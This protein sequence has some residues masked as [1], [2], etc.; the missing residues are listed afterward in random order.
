MKSL[1]CKKLVLHTDGTLSGTR[2]LLDDQLVDGV[3]MISLEV[4]PEGYDASV[5]MSDGS[6]RVSDLIDINIGGED[7]Q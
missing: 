2:L 7:E 3:K 6:R 1:K 5:I 4:S